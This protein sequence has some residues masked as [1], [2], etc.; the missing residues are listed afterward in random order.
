MRS[1]LSQTLISALG[2][3][4]LLAGCGNTTP[5]QST[6]DSQKSD[7]D[8]D[9][10]DS[11]KTTEMEDNEN[12]SAAESKEQIPDWREMLV[13]TEPADDWLKDQCV[14]IDKTL[15]EISSKTEARS[16]QLKSVKEKSIR[17]Q[18]K[19]VTSGKAR[20]ADWYDKPER[21]LTK[22][23]RS[24]V[25]LNNSQMTNVAQVKSEF[26]TELLE[27]CGVALKWRDL[28]SGIKVLALLQS[29][30]KSSAATY[31]SAS[32]K[33]PYSKSCLAEANR[34]GQSARKGNSLR[35]QED[36]YINAGDVWVSFDL[37]NYCGRAVRGFEY[38]LTLT[39]A[40]G[41][42]IFRGSG[43]M[44]SKSPI[45]A[46][47]IYK[48]NRSGDEGVFG[49]V[50]TRWFDVMQWWDSRQTD[51]TWETTITRVLYD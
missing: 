24:A 45:R 9:R 33:D 35:Y 18:I 36:N 4:V 16:A 25:D 30:V 50:G 48:V 19:F 34:P 17:R 51:A 20:D 37:V 38:R 2:A 21:V 28:L 5:S 49:F 43:K 32:Y 7:D 46:G 3:S 47:D 15:E 26:T 12:Q 31:M 29:D 42:Q 40:F 10:G 14:D 1:R 27:A 41:D 22:K 13:I 39:D 8:S 23:F 11:T 44:V 6:P